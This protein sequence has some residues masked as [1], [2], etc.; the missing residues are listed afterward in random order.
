MKVNKILAIAITEY[1]DESLNKLENCKYDLECILQI[2]AAKYNFDDIEFLH[3]KEDT[4]RREIHSKLTDY[5]LNTLPE[6]NVLLIFAGHGEYNSRTQMAY[7][8]P[9]DAD[10][11]DPSSWLNLNEIMGFIKAAKAHHIG[12]ISD[13]CFSGAILENYR[14]GGMDALMSKKSRQALTSGGLEKV[15]DGKKGENSPFTKALVKVL[16][17]NEKKELTFDVLSENV[18]IEFSKQHLQTPMRGSLSDVGHEGG[19]FIFQLKEEQKQPE[20][21]DDENEYLKTKMD[22]LYIPLS[23]EILKNTDEILEV[24]EQKN[25]VVRDQRYEEAARL[26]DTEKRLEEKSQVLVEAFID[27]LIEKTQLTDEEIAKSKHLDKEIEE[28][29]DYIEEQKKVQEK[30]EIE[31]EER[32]KATVG[33][34]QEDEEDEFNIQKISSFS[35]ESR[36]PIWELLYTTKENPAVNY[37]IVHQNELIEK[38]KSNVIELYCYFKTIQGVSKSKVI[39]EKLDILKRHLINICNYE[40]N[41]LI[42]RFNSVLDEEL[43]RKQIEVDFLNWLKNKE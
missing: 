12:I 30:I 35:F 26:R 1:D 3:K 20:M 5:F 41:I 13:S 28:Y 21:I 32:K 8:Q 42:G 2:L 31:E 43:V 7:W 10:S 11:K 37:F 34:I 23:E 39:S 33:E 22:N 17:E 36:I 16:A 15:S 27:S 25:Q 14:G 9:S 4:S 40:I 38:Y 6:D 19:S 18:V 24:R 29:N